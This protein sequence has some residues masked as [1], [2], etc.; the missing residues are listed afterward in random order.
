MAGRVPGGYREAVV[1]IDR[2]LIEMR[3]IADELNR[4][5]RQKAKYQKGLRMLPKSSADFSDCVKC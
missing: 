5:G 1:K 3:K 4:A 2:L